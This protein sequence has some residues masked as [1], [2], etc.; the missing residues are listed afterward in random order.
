[1]TPEPPDPGPGVP[2]DRWELGS[3]FHLVAPAGAPDAPDVRWPWPD[4]H[5]RLATGRA[6]L[7]ALVRHGRAARGW[8]RLWVPSHFCQEVLLPLGDAGVELAAYPAPAEQEGLPP[9]R[10]PAEPGDA[11]LDVNLLGLR[12]NSILSRDWPDGVEIVEDHT[13]DPLSAWATRSGADWCV[14]SLRKSLPLPDG[15]VLWSP[16]GHPLPA[17]PPAGPADG[18]EA[19]LAAMALK[20]EW[21]RGAS[22]DRDRYRRLEVDAERRLGEAPPVAMSGWS[23]RLLAGMPAGAWR[24][25]RRANHRAL[26]AALDG[27]A[28]ARLLRPDP[29]AVPFAATL[30]CDAAAVRDGLRERLIAAR[31]YPPVLW[32]LEPATV[33]GIPPE[34]VAASRR[35]LSLC[36]DFRYDAGDVRRVAGLVRDAL[37]ALAGAEA[38]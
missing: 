9:I 37:A 21:L 33:Q 34:H 13:H 12:A 7:V 18:V 29:D 5:R 27:A 6:A 23:E 1:M 8:R 15:A 22:D 36:C 26:A 32:P 2:T 11:V 20:R 19:R 25:R 35:L 3:H 17:P 28:G 31:V 10:I 16:R 4:A 30:L 24:E 14:A 38:S